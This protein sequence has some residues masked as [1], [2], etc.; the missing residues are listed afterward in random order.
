MTLPD[1]A[2]FPPEG[3]ELLTILCRPLRIVQNW[4]GRAKMVAFTN[5]VSTIWQKVATLEQK[6]TE[7]TRRHRERMARLQGERD[8]LLL[9][10]I[11]LEGAH[12]RRFV[13]VR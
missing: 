2:Q 13:G 9:K 11:D 7:E 12:D 3:V 10:L 4:A 8:Q 6:I 1:E 5:N